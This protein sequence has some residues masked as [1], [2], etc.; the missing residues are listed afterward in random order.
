MK[1]LKKGQMVM[2]WVHDKPVKILKV[3]GNDVIVNILGVQNVI[4]SN[5]CTPV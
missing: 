2:T 4:N 3:Q 5:M 1:K